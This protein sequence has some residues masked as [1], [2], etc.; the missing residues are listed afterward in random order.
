MNI[1]Q[2]SQKPTGTGR[3]KCTC[4]ANGVYEK[5]GAMATFSASHP[6]VFRQAGGS[7]VAT[8]H[9]SPRED[10]S[11]DGHGRLSDFRPTGDLHYTSISSGQLSR[12]WKVLTLP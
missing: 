12:I 3:V 4:E 6:G 10:K 2:N 1:G 9:D 8:P 11:L 7:D 5:S